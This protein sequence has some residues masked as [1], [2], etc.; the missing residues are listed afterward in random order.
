VLVVTPTGL[1]RAVFGP[2][3]RAGIDRWVVGTAADALGRPVADMVFRSGRI[4]AVYGLRLVDGGE[5]VLKVHRAPVDVRALGACRELLA[6]LFAAGYPCPEPLA[7]PVTRDGR[8]VTVESLM[9]EGEVPDARS[10]RVRRAM[11]GSFAEHIAVLRARLD[12]AG[13]L[14][15]GPAW[16]RYYDGPWP[17]PHDPIFDFA[18]TPA[19]FEWLDEFARDAAADVTRLGRDVPPVIAHGDWYEGNIRV[20][21]ERVV[22]VFDWDFVVEP[23]AVAV[24]LSA[25]GYLLHDAP[26]PAEVAAFLAEYPALPS[27]QRPL[28]VAAARWVLA[29]NARCDLAMLDGAPRPGS[30][31]ARLL[32]DRAAYVELAR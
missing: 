13:A 29:F 26:T 11:T 2:A 16:T 14:G 20:V 8:V 23:E 17:T 10:P 9:A 32:D 24:G 25:G 19:G 31:L 18:R 22:A 5:V 1:E 7:G 28:A 15:P 3:T 4:D 27:D 12:S 21:G 6:H 30:A